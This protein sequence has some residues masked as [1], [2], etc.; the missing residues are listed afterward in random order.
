MSP[1]CISSGRPQPL[2][3]DCADSGSSR[4][5]YARSPVAPNAA[6]KKLRLDVVEG[7]DRGTSIA[8]GG[9]EVTVGSGRGC[10]VVLTDPAVS[11]LHLRLIVDDRGVRVIDAGSRNGTILGGVPILD[12]WAE[13]DATLVIGRTTIALTRR[14]RLSTY[15]RRRTSNSVVFSGAAS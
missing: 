10:D 2:R 8:V 4:R 14:V 12:A 15:P 7:H 5:C 13:G 6:S 11:R 1:T 9:A 3:S